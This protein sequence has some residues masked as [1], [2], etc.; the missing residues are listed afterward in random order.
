[1][2][3]IS[4]WQV[5]SEYKNEDVVYYDSEF[6]SCI[7]DHKATSDLYPCI[8]TINL[9]HVITGSQYTK[10]SPT[11]QSLPV[12]TPVQS[13]TIQEPVNKLVGS[14]NT[15]LGGAPPCGTYFQSWSSAWS[16]NA[17]HWI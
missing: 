7:V 4:N 15:L 11:I 16:S 12:S 2:I 1:M 9:W 13:I 3:N 6:F 5:G 10:P 8:D 17:R 14:L